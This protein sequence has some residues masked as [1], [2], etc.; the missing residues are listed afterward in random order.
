MMSAMVGLH[1]LHSCPG[2]PPECFNH[3]NIAPDGTYLNVSDADA[4]GQMPSYRPDP[5]AILPLSMLTLALGN[6]SASSPAHPSPKPR[7]CSVGLLCQ[8]WDS[9]Q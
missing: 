6:T 3:L 1:C 2:K 7:P 4:Q 5:T 8:S 9:R